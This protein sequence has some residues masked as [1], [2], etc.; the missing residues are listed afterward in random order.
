MAKGIAIK[1]EDNL[2]RD[3]HVRAAEQGL[4]TQ[5]YITGLIERDLFPERFP[6][7]TEEQIEQLKAAL[8][9]AS[10]ALGDVLDILGNRPKQSI[11]PPSMK[12][13]G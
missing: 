12:L 1:V 11:E 13:G 4:S 6:Q 7:L 8:K 3:I 10:Q 5:Q 2:L 9:M